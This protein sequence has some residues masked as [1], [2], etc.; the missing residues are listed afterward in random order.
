[1]LKVGKIIRIDEISNCFVPSFLQH[2]PAKEYKTTDDPGLKFDLINT[3]YDLLGEL[4]SV[5]IIYSLP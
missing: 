3:V 4:V 2:D 5:I 1:M